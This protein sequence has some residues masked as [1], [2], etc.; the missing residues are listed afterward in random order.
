MRLGVVV[1]VVV[2][3]AGYALQRGHGA[4]PATTTTTWPSSFVAS[5]QGP[6]SASVTVPGSH[7]V[8]TVSARSSTRVVIKGVADN[9]F[10]GPLAAGQHTTVSVNERVVISFDPAA[11]TVALGGSSVTL[12]AGAKASYFLTIKPAS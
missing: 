12:P 8:I 2:V 7:F 6:H 11:A 10:H 9:Y 3:A 4:G 1:L 5:A